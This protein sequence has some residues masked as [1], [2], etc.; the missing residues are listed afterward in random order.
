[1]WWDRGTAGSEHT[2]LL[3]SFLLIQQTFSE[4]KKIFDIHHTLIFM[5]WDSKYQK[6]LF[7]LKQI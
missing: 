7:L 6:V 3:S 1:M 4:K 2:S 5:D